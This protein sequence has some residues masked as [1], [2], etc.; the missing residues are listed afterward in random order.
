MPVLRVVLNV[1]HSAV[2]TRFKHFKL[3]KTRKVQG[4]GRQFCADWFKN[5][6]WLVLC[7][8]RLKAYC[9][10]CRYCIGQGLLNDKQG[11]LAFITIGFDN[12][13]KA[14][15]RFDQH[16]K[17][18]LHKEAVL[19]IDF[20]KQ[21]NVLAQLDGQHKKDQHSRRQMLLVTLS[22]LR[23][24]LRQGL[25]IRGHDEAEGNLMQ[26]LLLRSEHIAG[27]KRY[28]DD[29]HYLSGEVVNEMIALMSKTAL[30]QLLSEIREALIFSIIADEATDIS[31][32][33]QLCIAIR[34]V[35]N[36]FQIHEAPIELIQVPK[37][38]AE[39]LAT[40]IK[41]SLTRLAL[42][43]A[44][45]RGQAYDGASNMSGH[46]RGVAAR[47]Q[48]VER[49][50]IYVH[51][52][53][54]CTNLCLQTAGKQLLCIREALDLVMGLGQ[55]IRFSPKRCSL[56]ETLQQQ[57]APGTP[58]LKPLCP[59]RWTVRTRAID[60]VV[61]NYS[62]LQ[63]A[64]GEIEHGKDEYAMKAVGYLNSMQKFG[65]Y[66]GLKLSHLIFS[67]TEQLSLNLQAKDTT[68]QE[69]IQASK[70][71]LEYIQRQRT[72]AAFD[73]FFSHVVA[74]C[75]DL[76]DPPTLPR[77]RR[78]P[79]LMDTGGTSHTFNNPELYFRQKYFEVLDTVGGELKHRFQQDRGM[80]MAAALEKVLLD[81][82]QETLTD[83][84]LPRELEM[85]SKD[86]NVPNLTIQ[87][88]MLPDLVRAFNENNPATAIKE[89]TTLRTLCDIMNGMP[90]SKVMFSEVFTLLRLVLTIPVTT[91]TAERTFSTLRRL[92][93]FLRSSMAQ[94]RLNHTVL[95]HIHKERTDSLDLLEIA[96]SF[97]SVNDRRRFYFG[98]F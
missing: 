32:K 25:A 15:Q 84:S 1:L 72:D 3:K 62:V 77:Q 98:N 85:Y 43:I 64:L 65:T 69:A 93:N 57:F 17:S 42:P 53:A 29:K 20:L 75:K 22:S 61:A 11:D 40:L 54:H 31:Q 24:L 18:S 86:I 46:I 89:V 95:L 94:P 80:P 81:A 33:E 63:D 34:W 79:Q 13:K 41:D 67:A 58:T 35:D 50:A 37:T 56:F 76:T 36:H 21:P 6:P 78:Q 87:L 39:T 55:L 68:L 19:K 92:K 60:A 73:S 38:D 49:N 30:R 59:T 45:C 90:S 71:A 8:T 5:R 23:Y 9:A 44:Q 10:H 66:F 12:W 96:K 48:E 82:T 52:V 2:K 74:D 47:I 27:L 14:L 26:L 7:T 28:I 91:A 51:C 83:D 97:V 4:H 70:L 16:T 88:K